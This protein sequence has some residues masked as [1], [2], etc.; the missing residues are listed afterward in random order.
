LFGIIVPA[1]RV[2][3]HYI[4][5]DESAELKLYRLAGGRELA[6]LR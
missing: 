4:V 6:V 5:F 1:I 3:K 2:V